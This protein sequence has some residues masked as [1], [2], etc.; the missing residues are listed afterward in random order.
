MKQIGDRKTHTACGPLQVGVK[1]QNEKKENKEMQV[2]YQ[3]CCKYSFV[4]L[5]CTFVKLL[6]MI[7]YYILMSDHFSNLQQVRECL[8]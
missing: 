4:K 5:F 1:I 2:E 7:Y 6:R 3:Y 8:I